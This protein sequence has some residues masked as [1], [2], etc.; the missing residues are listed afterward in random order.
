[1]LFPK[2]SAMIRTLYPAILAL[3]ALSCHPMH[4]LGA[5][6]P[7]TDVYGDPLPEGVHVRMGTIQLRHA[8]ATATFSADGHS[9]ISCAEDTGLTRHWDVASG[10]LK[11]ESQ[12]CKTPREKIGL[13]SLNGRCAAIA[14]KDV[15][16]IRDAES[17]EERG[18]LPLKGEEGVWAK[19]SADG[20]FLL[21]I[22]NTSI[23]LWNVVRGKKVQSC[24]KE[25]DWLIIVFSP[26]SKRLALKLK[27]Q[28]LLLWDTAGG[29]EVRTKEVA[30][31]P[32]CF[33]PDGETLAVNDPGGPVKLLD[34]ATL[35]EQAR[36]KRPDEQTYPLADL[37]YSPDGRLLAAT[38]PEGIFVWDVATRTVKHR[39]P[40]RLADKLTFAPDSKTV[41]CWGWGLDHEI[42]LWNAI[43]GKELHARPGHANLVNVLAVSP[44]G[45]L[46][47]SAALHNPS[48]H[49]WD[50]ATG[51]L[52]RRLQGCDNGVEVC[53]F[54]ADGKQ[55]VS[56][57]SE[58][59]IQVWNVADGKEVRRIEVAGFPDRT[60]LRLSP[61]GKCLNAI[62]YSNS[63]P[64]RAAVW[65][66]S[67]GKLL[68]QRPY[69]VAVYRDGDHLFSAIRL[70]SH[71]AFSPDGQSV[72]VRHG[73]RLVIED[74]KS[75]RILSLLP[76]KLGRPVAFSPDGQLIAAAVLKPRA[77]SVER[78]IMEGVRL[79][80]GTTGQE[81]ASIK[82]GDGD[83]VDFSRDGRLLTTIDKDSLH[84]W[85]VATGDEHFHR[86]WPENFAH[87]SYG[88]P[89]S[90]L[91]FLPNG[92]GVVTGMDDG[93]IL[94]W[95]VPARRQ[96]AHPRKLESLETLWTA[97]AGEARKAHVAVYALAETPAA[98]VPFLA[99]RLKPTAGIDAK[100]LAKLLAD[101]D[102][103]QFSLREAAQ[104]QLTQLRDDIEPAL[105]RFLDSKPTLEARR[106]IEAILATPRPV[107]PTA[108]LRELR[109][110]R[111]LEAIGTAEARQ[112]LRKLAGGAAGAR[113]TRE[114][115]AALQRLERAILCLEC[116]KSRPAPGR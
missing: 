68:A 110:I 101:I 32:M 79:I 5:P 29:K 43:V 115:K 26:D 57:G 52:L 50:A 71:V 77:D 107:P 41:A 94:I 1:M 40:E 14:I 47:A 6:P 100:L 4:L 69:K 98:T 3:A 63:V 103:D 28:D 21:V 58:G 48:L 104:Q 44:D 11:R 53:A 17:G 87:D 92:R 24:K 66:L 35:K 59:S 93:T 51:R 116:S 45:K 113:V 102:S 16:I 23:E 81:V 36:L 89:A 10:R 61:D 80:E 106:R 97:L 49:L 25:T 95:D 64:A 13:L 85:N 34:T 72:T 112:L 76:E 8:H 90:S 20:K 67:T 91:A 12:L 46:V 88:A 65:D 37:E 78:P 2:R 82:T 39:L 75:G 31:L 42:L 55:L 7:R 62:Q 70:D 22:R 74:V 30:D 105:R 54:S 19:P 15:V 33:S 83:F 99:D 111:V 108:T 38:G 84:I 56:G 96:P 60:F 9:L 73:Q 18:R 109:C 114:A 86:K 27:D